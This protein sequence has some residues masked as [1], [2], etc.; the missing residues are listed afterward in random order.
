MAF[1]MNCGKELPE[2]A[3]FCAEC[4]TPAG[5]VEEKKTSQRESVYEGTVFKCPNCGGDKFKFIKGVLS[6]ESEDRKVVISGLKSY[7]KE[8]STVRGANKAK[9]Y[10]K[11]EEDDDDT[12]IESVYFSPNNKKNK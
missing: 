3:K 1:C 4:G 7:L 5:M 2:G 8:R 10:L 6:S 12:V 9:H 11:K